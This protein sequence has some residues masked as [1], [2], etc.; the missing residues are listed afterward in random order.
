MACLTT[1]AHHGAAM[2]SRRELIVGWREGRPA[3]VRSSTAFVGPVLARVSRPHAEVSGRQRAGLLAGAPASRGLPVWG[4][5]S[6]TC[7]H[8]CRAE[9]AAPPGPA[10]VWVAAL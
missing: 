7:A 1:N 2:W 9:A 4:H 5:V 8:R 3:T 6:I 10:S